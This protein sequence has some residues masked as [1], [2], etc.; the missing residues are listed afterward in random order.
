M[1]RWTS[2]EELL[3]LHG[4]VAEIFRDDGA[5]FYFTGERQPGLID[6]Q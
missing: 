2:I 1:L 3:E 4:I 6:A 5:P